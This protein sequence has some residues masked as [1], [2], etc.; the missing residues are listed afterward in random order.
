MAGDGKAPLVVGDDAEVH[1]AAIAVADA[2]GTQA[3]AH[4]GVDSASMAGKLPSPA[5]F[6]AALM[7]GASS[8]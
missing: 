3:P 4:V 2:A 5:D 6:A 7:R 1:A 8:Q